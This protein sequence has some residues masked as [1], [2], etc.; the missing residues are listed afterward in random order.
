[1][2]S[3]RNTQPN[4]SYILIEALAEAMLDAGPFDPGRELTA[5]FLSQL[6]SDLAA[7]ESSDL[8]GFDAEHR[9]PDELLVEWAER[10]RERKVRSVEYSTGIRL[11]W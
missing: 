10:G 9:L 11:Q 1:V 5:Q 4:L 8:L 3:I 2:V 6:R 7:K